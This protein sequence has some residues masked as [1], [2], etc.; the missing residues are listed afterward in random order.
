MSC[1]RYQRAS[2]FFS[3][4]SLLTWVSALPRLIRSDAKMIE[5]LIS[6]MLSES[7][8][9]A[10]GQATNPEERAK[11]EARLADEMVEEAL[12]LL[13]DPGDDKRRLELFAW[14]V[15]SGRL[16]IR[17]AFPRHI[18]G[19][20]LFH[21]KLG[22]FWFPDGSQ[23]AF[24]GSANETKQGHT[25]HYESVDVYR[26]WISGDVDRVRV[27]QEQFEEAWAGEA[28]GLEVVK[29]S[30]RVLARIRK[31][32][33]TS[34]PPLPSP[35]STPE[36]LDPWRHQTEAVEKFLRFKAGVLEMATGTGKTRTALRITG[37]L[38]DRGSIEGV[39][40]CTTGTDLLDQWYQEIQKYLRQ[41]QLTVYRHFDA[42]HE[43]GRFAAHSSRSVLIV[44][45]ESLRGLFS[46]LPPE[47]RNRLFIVHDEVHGLGSANSRRELGGQ[48]RY[49]PF[50]L[51]LSAT[52]ERKYDPEGTEFIVEELGEVVYRFRLEDAIRRGIL[53]EFDYLPLGYELTESD[54]GRLRTIF[55][56]KARREKEGDPMPDEEVW[57][58]LAAV[59]KTAEAKPG[60]FADLLAARPEV[61]K[62]TIVFVHTR[63]YG[64][65][66]L[67]LIHRYTSRY[68]TY[69]GD[70]ERSRLVAFAHGELDCLITCHRIS[71]GIDIQHLKSIV[72]FSA[73]RARLETIQRIG[74]C[75]RAN[76]QEPNKK[77]LVVDFVRRADDSGNL[78]PDEDR[79]TWLS[80][81]ARVQREESPLL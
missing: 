9:K 81:L 39:V 51:G 40:V 77:A 75:L 78:T 61:L 25:T 73:D 10:L 79:A 56:L 2:G 7:D 50:R 32:V 74:R 15:A 36:P 1:E 71:Q 6:P 55:S 27:K 23:V 8:R 80:S 47:K 68:S 48:H 16:E 57:R 24:T 65:S 43:I 17:F 31:L 19:A 54:R 28:S 37:E 60:V 13:R 33:P 38:L 42:H 45:R 72:L 63:E 3:S 4:K 14:L 53:C 12:K 70:D 21:E 46:V 30:E 58:Q 34:L 22:I 11:L 29:L 67:D 26:S 5:L 20:D 49:F 35:P 64:N 69:Y 44:S 52:P 62:H 41:R 66:L 18:E 76:P 59:H